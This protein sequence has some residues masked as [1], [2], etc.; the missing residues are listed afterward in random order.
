MRMSAPT[1]HAIQVIA[2]SSGVPYGGNEAASGGAHVPSDGKEPYR[3]L[4]PGG[5]LGVSAVTAGEN[6]DPAQ[7]ARAEQ[8]VGCW[9][10]R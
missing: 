3:V 8:P 6:A 4:K 9:R 7:L 10:E 1:Q 5:R 2:G